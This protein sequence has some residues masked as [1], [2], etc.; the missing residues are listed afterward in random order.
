[1]AIHHITAIAGDPDRNLR[2]YART[3]GLRLIKLTVNYD[4]P[5]TYHFY[6]GDEL[7]RPGTILTFFPWPDGSP[8][9]LGTGLVAAVGFAIPPG[10]LGFWIER[11]LAQGVR[12]QGPTRRF[13]EPVLAFADP[14]GL[15]L[16]LIATERALE[17]PG[18]ADGPV[19]PEHAIRALHGATIWEDGD[20]G[21]ADLL[22]AQLDGLVGNEPAEALPGLR[23]AAAL[24]IE[25]KTSAL[26]SL[27]PIAKEPRARERLEVEVRDQ[28]GALD[29]ARDDEANARARVE[30]NAVDAEQ[31]AGQAERLAQWRE[32]L[33]AL[34]R[35][36]RVL[37]STL[38]AIDRA[39]QAT[40][41]TATRY[42]EAHMVR[43]L[44]AVTGG[45]YRRVRVD[46]RTL[47]I[48]VH[49]PEK[50]DWVHVSSL[51]QGTLDLVYL[52]ARLGLV[53]LVTGDR[54]PPLVFD[55]PF[56]TLDDTRAARA[57]ELLKSIATDFQVIYLTTSE[58]YDAVADLVVAL[59]GPTALDPGGVETDAQ[60]LTLDRAA[61][62]A[63]RGRA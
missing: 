18:W 19:P 50:G 23:D 24:E 20:S 10:S 59:I 39:E 45:R 33:A 3:L 40:M 52:V 15:A 6:F 36:Q 17:M 11:L 1:V 62:A 55:D 22:T 58:R 14:D 47:D 38:K 5:A 61:A 9:R 26:E 56:V 25:R 51:S 49:A 60:P 13:E 32:Q 35:R 63:P 7:G 53:R 43:D 48:E 29:R 4:D 44:A 42:L 46:D 16:E 27:G 31:V 21:A 12:Y 54:R 28:E 57:V 30:A 41:K 8:G 37:D 2:F 34:Q